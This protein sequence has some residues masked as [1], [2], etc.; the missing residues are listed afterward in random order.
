M[1]NFQTPE[2][3]CNI[4]VSNLHK[5]GTGIILEPTPGD[6]NLV[7][8]IKIQ[9]P[10]SDIITPVDFWN[11]DFSRFTYIDSIV[12][13]PPFSPM[14]VGYEILYRCMELSDYIIALMPWLTIINSQKRTNDI[15]N[16]GLSKIY[17]LPR[18]AFPGSRVQTCIM[19]LEKGYNRETI[20]ERG[21]RDV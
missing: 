2:W 8:A 4:M 20:F 5:N 10:C 21:V 18:I 17:H 19:V 15:F 12:M 6:G 14:K 3:V 1:N 13:N 11:Y 9:C 7:N 16:F